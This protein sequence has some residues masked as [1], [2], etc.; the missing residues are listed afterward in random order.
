MDY[1]D[2]KGRPLPKPGAV[3]KKKSIPEKLQ[4]FNIQGD[5]KTFIDDIIKKEKKKLDQYETKED[6]IDELKEKIDEFY[7]NRKNA[8]DTTK[9]KYQ[10]KGSQSKCELIGIVSDAQHVGEKIPFCPKDKNVEETKGKK[11]TDRVRYPPVRYCFI[12]FFLFCFIFLLNFL[13]NLF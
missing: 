3:S 2:G 11:V 8:N 4:R 10:V 7:K 5:R 12:N 9:E 6:V 13:F 1:L